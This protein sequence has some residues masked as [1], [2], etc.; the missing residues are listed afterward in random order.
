MM[1]CAKCEKSY[2]AGKK[3][4]L[5]CGSA[6][7]AREQVVRLLCPACGA[8][9]QA[10]KKFCHVCGTSLAGLVPAIAEPPKCPACGQEVTPGK[11]FCKHC[12][13]VLETPK[14]T[15]AVSR[16]SPASAVEG[17]APSQEQSGAAIPTVKGIAI[18]ESF[19]EAEPNLISGMASPPPAPPAAPPRR[20]SSILSG[21]AVLGPIAEVPP[22]EPA[23]EK[24]APVLSAAQVIARTEEAKP[25][26]WLGWILGGV[27]VVAVAAAVSWFFFFSVEA[28]MFRA[29][30]RGE[31]VSPEGKSAYDLFVE[32]ERGGV[33]AAL[34]QKLRARALPKLQSAGDALLQKRHD[35]VNYKES[36][37][38]D[39]G[40][41]CEWAAK[42]APEDA[43]AL[44]RDA[45]ARGLAK[46]VAGNAQEA[47]PEF[48]R[49]VNYDANW[50]V[51]FND[52]GR[53]YVKLTDHVH[54]EEA[55]SRAIG[56]DTSWVYPHVNL[57][58]V[59][60]MQKD[61]FRAEQ[62]YF[63]ATQLDPGLATPWFFLGQVYEAQ[64]RTA[65]AV[66]AY[67]KAVEL[68]AKRP[69]SAFSVDKVQTRI[70]KLRAKLAGP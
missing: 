14:G 21:S 43:K 59:Y 23:K 31:L 26:H 19:S 57:G 18:P 16:A 41:L 7:K 51:A 64:S 27:A 62:T 53:T 13:N 67:E 58:G 45:Y 12:G 20:T 33:D 32:I 36:E 49:A 39:L 5:E 38:K 9:V 11:K 46:L 34:K 3:F 4:C 66:G 22:A 50:V 68:A 6:L 30:D 52:L 24:V 1:Y 35:A 69:S 28:R 54:A 17:V 2:P 10:G 60:L 47:L 55:Y 8:E 61:W 48:Q 29:L 65:D 25:R 44:A 70:E 40:R 56:L 42:I 15:P 63:R 37:L